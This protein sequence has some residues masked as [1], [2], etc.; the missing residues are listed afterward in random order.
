MH[1]NLT[2][3]AVSSEDEA[4]LLEV[5]ASTR[6][7]ELARLP[8]DE[9]QR[10]GFVRMQ[11]LAQQQD[12]Q[13]RFPGGEHRLMLLDGRPAGRVYLARSD[14]EIRILDVALAPEYRNK[15]IGTTV[16]KDLLDEAERM[17]KPVR[18][19]VERFNPAL[20]L[21]ERLGFSRVEDIGSHILM[22]WRCNLDP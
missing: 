2:L 12:Y 22:E 17:H 18:V 15:G 6:A 16:I 3:R 14:E 19:Y 5:Y 4:F 21:F 11:F 7:D 8:W 1:M 20:D 13:R 10:Q 9:D